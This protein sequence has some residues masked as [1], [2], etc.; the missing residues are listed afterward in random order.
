MNI[1][2]KCCFTSL[3][4]VA[5]F[6]SC[7]KDND[8]KT[9]DE[10]FTHGVFISNEGKFQANN[11]S[12]SYFDTDSNKIINNIFETINGRSPGDIVQSVGIC[13]KYAFIIVNNSQKIEVVDLRSFMAAGVITGVSY[14]RYL[15]AVS[16]TK[17]YLTN[18]SFSGYIYVIDINNLN[19]SDSIVVG[20]GPEN[21]VISDNLVFVANSGGWATDNTVSIIDVN[22][23]EVIKTIEVGDCPTDLVKDVNGDIWVLCK[24]SVIYNWDPPYNIISETESSLVKINGESLSVEKTIIIG[25][26]GDYYNPKRLAI[27]NNGE[28]ILFD[29]SGGLYIMNIQDITAPQTPLIDKTFYGIEVDPASG[30]I[31]GFYSNGFE[32]SGYM[33]RYDQVGNIIDSTLV[34]I[35]PNGA[36]FN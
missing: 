8:L 15:I 28:S 29:E 27:S 6:F 35:A 11:G 9:L 18:G 31:Y 17:A 26:A 10:G 4:I 1:K 32:S 33:F 2:M 24:G 3:I 22:T 20:N 12:V 19:I 16:D 23:D 5:M 13:G 25:N 21:M 14:P 30:Y 36:I 7:T 34:G